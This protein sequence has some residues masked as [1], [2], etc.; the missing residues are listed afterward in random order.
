MG[1]KRSESKFRSVYFSCCKFILV[2]KFLAE[3]TVIYSCYA[4]G[5]G[6]ICKVCTVKKRI[7][8]Y[9]SNT[10]RYGDI[11]KVFTAIKCA[12]TYVCYA[13][14]NNN[15]FIFDSHGLP[16]VGI[17]SADAE[18]QRKCQSSCN[19]FLIHTLYLLKIS[20]LRPRE[21]N[22]PYQHI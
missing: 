2:G 12:F 21:R 15:F 5:C 8:A 6:N 20:V 16:L 11:R 1:F 9:A 17:S 7:L 10:V 13:I 3:R 4:V 22:T 18:N 19:Y 14:F